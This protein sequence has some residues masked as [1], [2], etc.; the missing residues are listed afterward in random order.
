MLIL[1]ATTARGLFP[2]SFL[3]AL[4]GR[5][6]RVVNRGTKPGLLFCFKLMLRSFY[7]CLQKS[8]V[9]Q[10]LGVKILI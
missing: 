3:S 7:I 1:G 5:I 9:K 10:V 2:L 8:F 4:L 6:G